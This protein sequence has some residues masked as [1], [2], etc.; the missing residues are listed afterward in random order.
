V[1]FIISSFHVISCNERISPQRR[2][3]RREDKEKKD[4]IF[5]IPSLLHSLAPFSPFPPVRSRF[6]NILVLEAHDY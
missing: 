5:P 4:F 1:I 6:L 2:G 3:E